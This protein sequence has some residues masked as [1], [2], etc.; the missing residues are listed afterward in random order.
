MTIEGVQGDL[1]AKVEGTEAILEKRSSKWCVLANG[2]KWLG[3]EIML[4]PK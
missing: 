2:K 3:V 4:F 1:W